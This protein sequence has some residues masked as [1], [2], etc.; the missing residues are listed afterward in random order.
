ML[1]LKKKEFYMKYCEVLHQNLHMQGF[2]TD[3]EHMYWSFTDSLVKT[4]KNGTVLVQVRIPA[5][6]LGD[7]D[8]YN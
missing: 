2:T 4:T 5:G 8:Y 7:I 1:E 6:H 3:G